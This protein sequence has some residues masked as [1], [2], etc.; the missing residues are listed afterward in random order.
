MFIVPHGIVC[1]GEVGLP[2]LRW[3]YCDLEVGYIVVEGLRIS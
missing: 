3:V 2:P 1:S